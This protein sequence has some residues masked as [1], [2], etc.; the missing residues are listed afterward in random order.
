MC[1]VTALHDRQADLSA[2]SAGEHPLPGQQASKGVVVMKLDRALFLPFD[3][4][5][6]H[7]HSPI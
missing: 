7:D 6:P 4:G 1:C 3:R 2:E 5:H